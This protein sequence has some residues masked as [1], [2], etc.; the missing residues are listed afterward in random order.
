MNYASS[1]VAS[2]DIRPF[3]ARTSISK[4][5]IAWLNRAA[6]ARF[7]WSG[8]L[9]DRALSVQP[10]GLVFTETAF[11]EQ[12]L[13][14]IFSSGKG[15]FTLSMERALADEMLADLQAGLPL[16]DGQAR[17]VLLEAVLDPLMTLV[18]AA[19]A[20]SLE[21]KVVQSAGP[22]L[23]PL[24]AFDIAY[25]KAKAR[26]W[27]RLPSAGNAFPEP[28][29]AILSG[30]DRLKTRSFAVPSDFPLGLRLELGT[31]VLSV[32]QLHALRQGDALIPE[33]WP[34]AH[35]Q[36]R[37]RIGPFL[38]PALLQNNRLVLSGALHSKQ[39]ASETRDMSVPTHDAT[40]VQPVDLDSIEVSL[41]FEFGRWPISLGEMKNLANGYVFD[42]AR[43]VDGPIDIMANGKLLGRGEI[44]QIGDKLGV[45]LI[46]GFDSHE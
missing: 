37:A 31:Q 36:V 18:E 39:F 32:S 19:L 30:L 44:V 5:N 33:D 29:L 22:I 20:T 11:P 40:G 15:S 13:D 6:C 8:R 35:G 23:G 25:G 14:L 24:L 1:R 10:K 17:V 38:A 4:V 3:H 2:A 42:L 26:A 16:P 12:A 7:P 46:E 34:L 21:L 45:R 43:P 41:S 9:G 28:C 27:L